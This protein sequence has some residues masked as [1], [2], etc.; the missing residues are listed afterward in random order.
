M[1]VLQINTVCGSGSVGRITVDIA[2]ALERAGDACRIAYGRRTA[3]EGV[4]SWRFGTDADMAVHVLHTFFKGEQ[5]FASGKQTARLIK[6]IRQWDPDIIHLHN[7]H[8]FYLD[9][10]QLFGYLRQA[11][12]PVVWTLHDCWA[13]TG[14]CA[15]FDY[16]GCDKWKTLC[17]DCPQHRSAYPYALF[18]DNSEQ[19]YLRKK[20]MLKDQPIPDMTLVTPCRW[21][22]GLVK[23]SFLMDYPV[24]VIYNG[25]DLSRFHPEAEGDLRARLGLEGKYVILGGANMWEKRKGYPYFLELAERLGKEYQVILIGLDKKKLKSLPPGVLG[26]ARTESVEELAAYYSM[27]DVYVNATLEDNFPTT[28][29][30]A[31]A[32]GTPVITFATGG[33]VESV[34]AA[35]G[36]IVPKGDLEA[37][38][39]AV[40]ELRGE[41]DKKEACL[42]RAALYDKY[43]RFQEYLELYRSLL[44]K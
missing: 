28:N 34:D 1:K 33:S 18:K 39:E 22:A 30:E 8:G 42:K 19:N 29:L 16:V 4:D 36:K 14:H 20:R 7:L 31:L 12:K 21:L 15:Y 13:F 37:L 9:T 41:P 43:D 6:E 26:L 2:H 25:I 17:H 11:G 3:P 27:A 5:G 24:R 38:L 23:Q 40:R 32:C 44:K 10:E 35:C